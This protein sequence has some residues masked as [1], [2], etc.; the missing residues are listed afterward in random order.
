MVIYVG[1]GEGGGGGYGGFWRVNGYRLFYMY[2]NKYASHIE[3]LYIYIY[4]IYIS[5]S[6]IYSVP[7]QPDQIGASRG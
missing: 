1:R 7:D 2:M 6:N 3:Y 4:C 5:I